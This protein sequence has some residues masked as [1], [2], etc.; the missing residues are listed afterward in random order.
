MK[1]DLSCFFLFFTIQKGSLPTSIFP[2][3]A[4]IKEPSTYRNYLNLS[5]Y[6]QVHGWRH[7]W[8][9][10]ASHVRSPLGDGG[11]EDQ[12]YFYFICVW[13]AKSTAWIKSWIQNP[14][15]IS[16]CFWLNAWIKQLVPAQW[17]WCRCHF[18]FCLLWFTSFSQTEHTIYWW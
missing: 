10:K 1:D 14:L 15:L 7:Q 8:Q 5:K 2:L 6:F 11:G 17:L 12:V 18:S 16:I 4:G 3:S 9:D 13:Q